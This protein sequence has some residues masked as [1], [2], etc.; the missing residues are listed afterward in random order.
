MT[1]VDGEL[2]GAI[3]RFVPGGLSA[4]VESE[5]AGT[6][7]TRKVE[8][9][10]TAVV[11]E[12]AQTKQAIERLRTLLH[13]KSLLQ[14]ITQTFNSALSFPL[15]PSLLAST[16]SSLI[17]VNPPSLDPNAEEKG[18]T[19]LK[20]LR[21]EIDDLLALDEG[22]RG[23]EEELVGVK[24]ARERIAE[25]REVVGVW[26]GTSEEKARMKVVEGLEGIVEEAVNR[27]RK[28]MEAQRAT[29]NGSRNT[30]SG[31]RRD[32]VEA[33]A[34]GGGGR[35]FLGNLQRLREEIYME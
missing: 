18:Q 5:D 9:G 21:R 32:Q 34:P 33:R 13:V 28:V 25:L 7:T 19:A 16:G 8:E 12:E 14:Q 2:G 3:R 4:K 6:D 35:G 20:N 24:K 15:P 27:R 30:A 17:S 1:A 29:G 22:S 26:K 10:T 31:P 23:N 11:D